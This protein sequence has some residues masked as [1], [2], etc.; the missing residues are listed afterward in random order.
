MHINFSNQISRAKNGEKR[1]KKQQWCFIYI[2][3]RV[4]SKP[5]R[6]EV[7]KFDPPKRIFIYSEILKM[8]GQIQK[9]CPYYNK[10]YCKITREKERYWNLHPK[11]TC[12]KLNCKDKSCEERHPKPCRFDDCC[13]FQT[14]CQYN[15]ERQAANHNHS[16]E[17]KSLTEEMDTLKNRV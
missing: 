6:W 5:S 2:Y 12:K 1:A 16:E 4:D 17:V 3:C 11:N 10:G 9:K 8:A 14:R 13:R 7:I 15:H